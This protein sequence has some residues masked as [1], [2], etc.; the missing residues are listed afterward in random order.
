MGVL[1]LCLLKTVSSKRHVNLNV[2]RKRF[3]APGRR[4]IQNYSQSE[5]D[6]KVSIVE[7][8]AEILREIISVVDELIGLLDPD[9]YYLPQRLTE[10]SEKGY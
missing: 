5:N 8:R 6:S 2:P 3:S 7:T 4:G 1:W 10:I 9:P